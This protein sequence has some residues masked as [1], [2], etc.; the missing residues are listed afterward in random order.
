MNVRCSALDA[1]KYVITKCTNDREAILNLQ[2]QKILY[3]MQKAYINKFRSLLFRD[4]IEAWKYGPSIPSVYFKY[5]TRVCEPIYEEY[6][7]IEEQLDFSLAEILVLDKVIEEKRKLNAWELV[8]MTHKEKAW[9]DA[10]TSFNKVISPIS[11]L[12]DNLK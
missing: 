3:Y 2:L 4:K 7:G 5:A 11:M 1:A 12:D 10:Y 8:E 6:A 9:V